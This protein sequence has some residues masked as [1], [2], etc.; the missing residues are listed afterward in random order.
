MNTNNLLS[1]KIKIEIFLNVTFVNFLLLVLVVLPTI[2][3][4]ISIENE[5]AEK[6]S[7]YFSILVLLFIL[8]NFLSISYRI[9]VY[10]Y[11]VKD[12]Y[13]SVRYGFFIRTTKVIPMIKILMVTSKQNIIERS[14]KTASLEVVT[15]GANVKINHI[16][17]Q[18]VDELNRFIN[19]KLKQ[20]S[21]LSSEKGMI[22]N[23]LE[24][25]S[26]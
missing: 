22:E 16:D 25:T 8:I 23:E 11:E 14:L 1:K 5:V 2:I 9:K 7:M 19:D 6:I 13:L 17:V 15:A 12:D 3:L 10:R 26:E 24:E 21:N 4:W 20:K 18:H